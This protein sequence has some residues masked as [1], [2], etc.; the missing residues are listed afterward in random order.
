[1]PQSPIVKMRESPIVKWGVPVVVLAA[2][3][4]LFFCCGPLGVSGPVDTAKKDSEPAVGAR[5]PVVDEVVA[6]DSVADPL[7]ANDAASDGSDAL[8]GTGSVDEPDELDELDGTGGLDTPSGAPP[9]FPGTGTDGVAA[10]RRTDSEPGPPLAGVT[11][12]AAPTAIGSDSGDVAPT[13]IGSDP[14]DGAPFEIGNDALAVPP[15]IVASDSAATSSAAT[16]DGVGASA[17]GEPAASGA[18]A[19]GTDPGGATS[20]DAGPPAVDAPGTGRG[21]AAGPSTT[22]EELFAESTAIPDLGGHPKYRFPGYDVAAAQ[23]NLGPGLTSLAEPFDKLEP[24]DIL[25]S[26]CVQSMGRRFVGPPW[27]DYVPGR[28]PPTTSP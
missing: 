18:D 25:G 26:D 14:G 10:E 15:V 20:A 24:C 11:E 21:G 6:G 2:L 8:T 1:M 13:A 7:A 5:G 22:L 3:A 19:S 23:S 17:A 27:P 16:D 4:M 12:P 9:E 28:L